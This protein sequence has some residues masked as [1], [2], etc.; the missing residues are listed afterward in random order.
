MGNESNTLRLNSKT[1]AKCT[2]IALKFSKK[3]LE[4]RFKIWTIF[5]GK[6]SKE[7]NNIHQLQQSR[8]N[9]FLIWNLKIQT[10]WKTYF[11]NQMTK[12]QY[13]I[14]LLMPK[15]QNLCYKYGAIHTRIAMSF[16]VRFSY[17]F[18]RF[19]FHSMLRFISFYFSSMNESS[20]CLYLL[21]NRRRKKEQQSRFYY[22][23][24]QMHTVVCGVA[25][26]SRNRS[27]SSQACK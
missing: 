27:G 13:N 22:F 18:G 6:E 26:R 7:K 23:G 3:K 21:L 2:K 10:K 5:G 1:V 16:L 17:I 8:K 24:S 19:H 12:E 14:G 4:K 25:N 11:T 20:I 9:L 15:I